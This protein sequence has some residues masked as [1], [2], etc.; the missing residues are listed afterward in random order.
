MEYIRGI[1]DN[2]R[3]RDAG[4][5]SE[6][7]DVLL[8]EGTIE[9]LVREGRQPLLI[10]HIGNEAEGQSMQPYYQVPPKDIRPGN[11]DHVYMG[12]GCYVFV[13]KNGKQKI[14]ATYALT[15]DEA[16]QVENRIAEERNRLGLAEGEAAP[17]SEPPLQKHL[18]TATDTFRE[19]T[20]KARKLLPAERRKAREER[21]GTEFA[22]KFVSI[23]PQL[24]EMG[25]GVEF[26]SH[27]DD[28]G[29]NRKY[30]TTITLR[31]DIDKQDSVEDLLRKA[32]IEVD[33]DPLYEQARWTAIGL[34]R[35]MMTDE[36]YAQEAQT[37]QLVIYEGWNMSDEDRHRVKLN[38][39]E[40]TG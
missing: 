4:E 31:T 23:K 16:Q 19:L 35:H 34:M 10:G 25:C 5:T 29:K 28:L 15:E 22:D 13:F 17:L 18:D 14:G 40:P 6:Q 38:I 30:I 9:Q 1:T 24:T 11:I 39:E 27:A 8:A 12:A 3:R 20:N 37:G 21:R 2:M 33:K 7:K 32:E 26:S 36:Q